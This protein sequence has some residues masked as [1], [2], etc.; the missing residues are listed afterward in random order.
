V[1]IQA[2]GVLEARR[3]VVEWNFLQTSKLSCYSEDSP[4]KA[5][6]YPIQD[7]IYCS[8]DNNT[9][10]SSM[11]RTSARP[12]PLDFLLPSAHSVYDIDRRKD[13]GFSHTLPHL[14]PVYLEAPVRGGL[15]TPPTPAGKMAAAYPPQYKYEDHS[16][17][18]DSAYS[19]SGALSGYIPPYNGAHVPASRPYSTMNQPPPASASASASTLQNQV[20][21]HH[22]IRT[23][24][25]SP[26]PPTRTNATKETSHRKSTTNDAIRPNLQIPSTISDC[27]GSLPDFAAQVL[28]QMPDLFPTK[29]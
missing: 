9:P 18:R 13:V 23:Q 8:N 11:Y 25:P 21:G 12:A 1:R 27:G 4:R 26:Q 14:P 3:T 29:D 22:S 28:T 10:T 16:G 17:R 15:R 24:P 20:L 5:T 7:N 19:S 6:H 2:E